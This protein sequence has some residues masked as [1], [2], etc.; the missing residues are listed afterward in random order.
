MC[1]S[2]LAYGQP[3]ETCILSLMMLLTVAS[4]LGMPIVRRRL[5]HCFQS[6]ETASAR[7]AESMLPWLAAI[8]RGLYRSALEVLERDA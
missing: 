5:N 6:N 7:L 2:P 1:K 3:T 8:K 4:L